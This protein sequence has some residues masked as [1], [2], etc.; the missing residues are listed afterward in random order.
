MI[1]AVMFSLS[2]LV[3]VVLRL[4]LFCVD[5]IHLICVASPLFWFHFRDAMVLL[6]VMLSL[7]HVDMAMLLLL[8]LSF[9]VCCC[10]QNSCSDWFSSLCQLRLRHNWWGLHLQTL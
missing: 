9:S 5:F 10:S 7:Y 1:V 8:V 4:I 3:H 2:L 6:I